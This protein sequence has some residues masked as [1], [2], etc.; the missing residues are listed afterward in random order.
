[1]RL[2]HA[3]VGSN[4]M[5][6]RSKCFETARKRC[7]N[8]VN[9]DTNLHVF[10]AHTMYQPEP[11]KAVVVLIDRVVNTHVR[12]HSLVSHTHSH[13]CA[14]VK[15]IPQTSSTGTKTEESHYINIQSSQFHVYIAVT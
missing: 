4:D 7:L 14:S 2:V 12:T 15:S 13:K 9:D 10:V 3:F 1:M 5:V 11:F 8:H 6:N